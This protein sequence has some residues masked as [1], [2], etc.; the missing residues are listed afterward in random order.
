MWKFVNPEY[1]AWKFR[2]SSVTSRRT[3]GLRT[4]CDHFIDQAPSIPSSDVMQP[5]FILRK[6]CFFS[7]D[8][9]HESIS[10]IGT[11]AVALR[12][13]QRRSRATEHTS[14]GSGTPLSAFVTPS[15]NQTRGQAPFFVNGI[16]IDPIRPNS[17]IHTDP[18]P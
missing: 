18:I 17:S 1:K 9:H 14:L 10:V 11:K 7:A 5:K 8:Q 6:Q 2:Q 16:C 4:V 13:P 12:I 3:H 15:A